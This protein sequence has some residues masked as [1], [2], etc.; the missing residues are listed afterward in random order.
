MPRQ[1]RPHRFEIIDLPCDPSVPLDL[2][3]ALYTRLSDD[4]DEKIS[5]TSQQNEVQAAFG[6]RQTLP[7]PA[8]VNAP[9]NGVAYLA[10]D[11]GYVITQIIRDWKTGADPKRLGLNRGLIKGAH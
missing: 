2:R 8:E 1:K 9:T 4:D 5:H 6:L 3:R 7:L 11:R 10:H